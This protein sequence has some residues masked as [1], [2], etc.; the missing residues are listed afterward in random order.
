MLKTD[1][2]QLI[3]GLRPAAASYIGNMFPKTQ[4][5]EAYQRPLSLSSAALAPPEPELAV[6]SLARI[7]ELCERYFEWGK[8]E[9]I[10]VK[11][12]KHVWPGIVLRMVLSDILDADRASVSLQATLCVHSLT[13]WNIQISDSLTA[14][15]AAAIPRV[16]RERASNG[17]TEYMV[18]F[19]ADHL[20]TASLSSLHDSV[21]GTGDKRAHA[22]DIDNINVWIPYPVYNV[23]ISKCMSPHLLISGLGEI[24]PVRQ[25]SRIIYS[26]CTDDFQHPNKKAR[27]CSSSESDSIFSRDGTASPP[28]LASTSTQGSALPPFPPPLA[29]PGPSARA[30]IDLTGPGPVLPRARSTSSSIVDVTGPAPP[31]RAHSV[32]SS[33][34]DLTGPASPLLVPNELV[35]S[36]IDL[37]EE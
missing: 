31:P 18:A 25:C 21:L 19:P 20:A 11:L 16:I 26:I 34:L 15:P 17:I 2:Q 14:S 5:L 6:P 32:S 24:P 22:D 13:K 7:A 33:I 36:V 35:G 12:A 1:P 8:H 28:P 29:A 37:T 9:T 10:S 23:W 27:V 30:V 4:V 3:G